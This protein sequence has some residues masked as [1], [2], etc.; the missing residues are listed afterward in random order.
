MKVLNKE[1]V[2]ITKWEHDFKWYASSYNV[3]ILNSYNPELQFKDTEF[4]IKNKLIECCLSLKVLKNDDKTLNSNF[5]SNLKA[6]TVVEESDI[7]DVLKSIYITVISYLQKSLGQGSGWII[8][9]VTDHSTNISKYSSL[10]GTRYI[11]LPRELDHPKKG[12]INIQRIDDDECFKWCLVRYLHPVD[13][14][15]IRIAKADKDFSKWLDFKDIKLSVKTKD[16]HKIEK[17]ELYQD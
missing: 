12:L 1:I 6:E 9:S 3:E 13:R 5:Y 8:N 15:P 4:T 7:D 10:A 17:Q 14:N 2:K 16:I 11:K